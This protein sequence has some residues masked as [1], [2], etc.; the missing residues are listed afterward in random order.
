MKSHYS[1]YK[2]GINFNC[3]LILPCEWDDFDSKSITL[4]LASDEGVFHKP[5]WFC[6]PL[7]RVERKWQSSCTLTSTTISARSTAHR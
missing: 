3:S 6:S 4:Y 1:A 2:D 7:S 5:F